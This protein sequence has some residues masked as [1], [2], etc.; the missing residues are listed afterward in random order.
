MGSLCLFSFHENT[1]YSANITSPRPKCPCSIG[2]FQAYP[3]LYMGML[4][5]SSLS[6]IGNQNGFDFLASRQLPLFTC[7]LTPPSPWNLTLRPSRRHK[8]GRSPD[9][10]PM[11]L[12]MLFWV[13][14]HDTP[15]GSTEYVFAKFPWVVP[16]VFSLARNDIILDDF[17]EHSYSLCKSQPLKLDKCGMRKC[18]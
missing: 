4:A 18:E 11:H 14:F 3:I 16:K 17:V 15:L 5:L 12:F 10:A 1:I 2:R 13:C 9:F 8:L 6:L 7:H